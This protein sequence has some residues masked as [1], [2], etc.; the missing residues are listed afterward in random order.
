MKRV[1]LSVLTAAL[2]SGSALAGGWDVDKPHTKI[3]FEVP[4][5][6][7]STVEG[8]FN[9][10]EATVNYDEKNPASLSFDVTI[11]ASS[12]YTNNEKRDGHLKSADFFDVANH[13]NITFKST[14]TDV[15]SPGKFKVTGDLTIRGITKSVTLDVTGLDKVIETPWGF[16]KAGVKATGTVNRHDFDLKW[17]QTF[18]AGELIAGETVTLNIVAELNEKK[19]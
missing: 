3:G 15:V 7:I 5:M 9:T 11:D 13:P 19:D 18:G 4:H 2:T 17:D 16:R 14:K 1:I 6:M 12:V 8:H 10:Y